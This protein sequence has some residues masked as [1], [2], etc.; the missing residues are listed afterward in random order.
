MIDQQHTFETT[1]LRFT[2][3][4]EQSDTYTAD[5]HGSSAAESR[6]EKPPPFSLSPHHEK[7]SDQDENEEGE[8]TGLMTI[9]V[10]MLTFL[11]L[12]TIWGFYLALPY[13]V[14]S[15][16]ELGWTV[17]DL[18]KIFVSFTIG[19]VVATQI[20]MVAE[21]CKT[22]KKRV[23]FILDLMT[24]VAG[25]IGIGIISTVFDFHFFGH[26]H[27]LHFF[28]FGSFL[29]GICGDD[30]TVLTY[31]T[32]IS[33]DEKIQKSLV[34]RIGSMIIG[35]A[36]IDSFLLP[37]VY[38]MFGFQMFCG[39]LVVMDLI[40]VVTMCLL[41]YLIFQREDGDDAVDDEQ[42]SDSKVCNKLTLPM[43][44]MLL[45]QTIS[46]ALTFVYISS[47]PIAFAKD[48]GIG[49]TVG[50]YLY[51]A[52]ALFSFIVLSVLLTL[53]NNFGICQ[54]PIDQILLLTAFMIGN[55]FYVVFY[56]PWIAYT[57]H[58]VIAVLPTVMR[59]CERVT[60]LELCPP[61]VFNRLT[62]I[63]GFFKICA[64]SAG[65]YLGPILY[66][67]WKRLPF[68]VLFLLSGSLLIAIVKVY[69]H[70]IRFLYALRTANDESMDFRYLLAERN[71][72]N[73][74]WG[75]M[76]GASSRRHSVIS[77]SRR[78]SKAD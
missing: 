69:N 34:A 61:A 74:R 43:F 70:R 77:M 45:I 19:Q 52:S 55:A 13:Y 18:S 44:M 48:F 54:Y 68:M 8:S 63:G 64:I 9:Y 73:A 65:A 23:F 22:H 42:I 78:G 41:W 31:S 10:L 6:A 26:E 33:D 4:K 25:A 12:G 50:G 2:E 59:G 28:Y 51:A 57:A 49:A 35:T 5:T 11:H 14:L 15:T 39:V 27:D 24:F 75:A 67:I 29:C 56:A 47:Y 16:P 66:S 71:H 36:I 30:N 17:S 3:Q 21:C 72:Y 32:L 46:G 40:A 58:W 62:S 1:M 20:S 37:A 60:R 76:S 7:C 38:E 53:S